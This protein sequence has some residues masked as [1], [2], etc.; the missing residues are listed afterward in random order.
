MKELISQIK[1]NYRTYKNSIIKE[2]ES[3]NYN[4]MRYNV[5]Y[6]IALCASTKNADYE[7]IKQF[8]RESDKI[9]FLSKNIFCVVFGFVNHYEGVKASQNLRL[10]LEPKYFTKTLYMV[11]V[12]SDEVSDVNEHSRK[13]LDSILER[14]EEELNEAL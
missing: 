1:R 4:K 9:I 13:L 11:D 6:S 7:Y 5:N 10:K 3:Y 2:V 12:N 14:L 8:V